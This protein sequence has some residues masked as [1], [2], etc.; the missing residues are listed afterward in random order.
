MWEQTMAVMF[1]RFKWG[2]L[3]LLLFLIV[4]CKEDR[5]SVTHHYPSGIIEEKY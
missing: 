1:H 3:F 5:Q 2:I 4:A